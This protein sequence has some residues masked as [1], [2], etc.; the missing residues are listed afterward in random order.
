ME[1]IIKDTA[2]K[3]T[4]FNSIEEIKKSKKTK[5]TT[6]NKINFIKLINTIILF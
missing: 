1:I 6:R 2:D 3:E 4:A 5:G